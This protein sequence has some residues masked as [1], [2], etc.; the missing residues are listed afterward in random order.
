MKMKYLTAVIAIVVIEILFY[1]CNKDKGSGT[2]GAPAMDDLKVSSDFQWEPS[3]VVS[4]RVSV[5][6]SPEN[7]GTL[8]RVS[9]FNGNPGTNG[10][11]L[12]MGSAGYNSPFESDLRIPSSAK[13]LYLTAEDGTGVIKTDSV[14][15]SDVINYSFRQAALKSE[16]VASSDPDCSEATPAKT[17]SGNQ[18]YNISNGSAYYVTGDFSGTINFGGTGGTITV[19]GNMHPASITN[20]GNF[21]Y[22]VVAPGGTFHYNN[23]LIMGSGSRIYSYT[24]SHVNLG[25]LVMTNA[26]VWNTCNDWVVNSAFTPSGGME[27]YGSMHMFDA[28]DLNTS[29]TTLVNTGSITV[30]GNMNLE[31]TFYNNGGLEVFGH[32]NLNGGTLYNN[33]KFIVHND[34]V[35]SSGSITMN[36]AYLKETQL[37]QINSGATLLLKNNSMLSVFDYVQNTTVQGSGGGSEIKIINTGSV[38]GSNKVS[39]SIEMTTP[40][41]TLTTGNSTNFTNGAVLRKFTSSQV[42]LPVS[43]CNPEGMGSSAAPADLDADGVP[44]SIDAYPSDPKRAFDNYYPSKTQFGTLS[45]EDLWPM[46]GDYDM[47]DLVIDYRYQTVT[48]AQN[49]VVDIKPQFYVRAAGA[50][51]ANGFGFQINGILPGQ[52]ASVTGCSSKNSIISTSSN[53]VENNQEKAVVI[54]FDNFNNVIHRPTGYSGL[55]N[56]VPGSQT[57]YG[58]TLKVVIHLTAP[59]PLSSV[60]TPPYNPFMIKNKTRSV[61]IHLVDNPPTSLANTTLFGTGDDRSNPATGK[62]Y[63]TASNLPWALNIPRKFDYMTE[64]IPVIRGYLH[65]PSWAESSGANFPDWYMNNTG[66]RAE[67][68]IY[69]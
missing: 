63:K 54:V 18:T 37:F 48:N 17:L 46:A 50:G 5:E 10:N 57:G 34:L 35:L 14:N 68:N 43:T 13:K 21:C 58:D 23:T 2:S 61:E 30:E 38:S 25:G 45:F 40:T 36:G 47:N 12:I 28:L 15:I 32:F 16:E 8:S 22:I 51:Y 52:V 65:F 24:T 29:A 33:C 20:M 44:N 69:H 1:G 26:R 4:V 55:Y 39:G 56:T 59:L 31:T 64:K 60:G 49:Y 67:S 9:V 6:L 62:Y 41:G 66:Y 7:V 19:C 3:H 42:V 27:N 53:G 11:L